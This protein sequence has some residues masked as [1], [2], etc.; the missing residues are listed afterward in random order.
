MT[1]DNIK[2]VVY[3]VTNAFN[4]Y[5]V[6]IFLDH[7]LVK[8]RV[9][10]KMLFGAYF[11]FY[12]LNSGIFL[13]S[14]MQP[15]PAVAMINSLVLIFCV[16]LCYKAAL[17]NQIMYSIFSLILG[18][19]TENIVVYL[20]STFSNTTY[21]ETVAQSVSFIIMYITSK[22]LFY[23][24]VKIICRCFSKTDD[25]EIPFS[26]WLA[27]FI[28]PISSLFITWV[29]MRQSTNTGYQ[30]NEITTVAMALLLLINFLIFFLYEQI[31]S[32]SRIKTQNALLSLQND[33]YAKQY[34][35]ME[36]SD[37]ETRRLRH[38]LRGH[39][40]ALK[41][42]ADNGDIGEI[43]SYIGS[44]LGKTEYTGTFSSCGILAIDGVINLKMNEAAKLGAKIGV[45]VNVPG[46]L[47]IKPVDMTII[48]SNILDN[49]VEA[50]QH[51]EP[52]ERFINIHMEY[53]KKNMFINV[54]NSCD[55]S[56]TAKSNN[57]MITTKQ[58]MNGEK[59][60]LGLD[61]V[62]SVVKKYDGT[63]TVDKEPQKFIC[64]ILLYSVVRPK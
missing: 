48:L 5:V 50:C 38:D 11:C 19:A 41:T 49:A 1:L 25:Y 26:Y 14:K 42:Y 55:D 61:N 18:A 46:N 31:I 21:L 57:G 56:L 30:L 51:V 22:I 60:G 17:K 13:M 32:F 9:S 23:I 20:A 44:L 2:V 16:S 52:G 63:V 12:A 62:R 29:I 64:S 3:L 47:E 28:V 40:S 35:I 37:A 34:K 53:E 58:N 8:R 36:E 27:T 45:T 15:V 6:K 33:Y 7:F 4:V 10:K 43:D 24:F 59:H 39:L 54:V